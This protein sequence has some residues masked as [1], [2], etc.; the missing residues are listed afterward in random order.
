M[1][2]TELI[3]SPPVVAAALTAVV[4]VTVF[5]LHS[6]QKERRAAAVDLFKQFMTSDSYL[7]ARLI[8]QE[9]LVPGVDRDQFSRFEGKNFEQITELLE[10]ADN[11]DDREARFYIRAIPSFFW[12]VNEAAKNGYISKTKLFSKVYSYYYFMVI[13]PRSGPTSDP[14]YECFDWMMTKADKEERKTEYAAKLAVVN[15]K[16]SSDACKSLFSLNSFSFWRTQT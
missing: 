13:K 5:V 7:K 1:S 14:L 6:R 9:Y 3:L 10:N 15:A 2:V 11:P 12:T 4:T 16:T 8:T